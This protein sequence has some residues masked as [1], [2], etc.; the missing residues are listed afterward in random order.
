MIPYLQAWDNNVEPIIEM[1]NSMT[2]LCILFLAQYTQTMDHIRIVE[3]LIVCLF[4][5]SFS[6]FRIPCSTSY[7][8]F[9]TISLSAN[10]FQKRFFC[11]TQLFFSHTPMKIFAHTDKKHRIYFII[12]YLNFSVMFPIVYHHFFYYFIHICALSRR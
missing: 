1:Y 7:F 3:L 6:V 10:T 5:T 11:D 4:I 8:T 12:L 9:E 2:N